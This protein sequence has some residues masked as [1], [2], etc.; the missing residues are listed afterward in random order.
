MIF[1]KGPEWFRLVKGIRYVIQVSQ[2]IPLAIQP[3]LREIDALY[4]LFCV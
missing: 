3:R 4:R 2:S 1:F